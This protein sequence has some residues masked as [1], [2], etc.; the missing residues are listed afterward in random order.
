MAPK[1]GAFFLF[2]KLLIHTFIIT[3]FFTLLIGCASVATYEDDQ[4][5][6]DM[7]LN[8]PKSWEGSRQIPGIGG[9][10]GRGM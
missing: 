5:F 6:S 7:P 3:V 1:D 4:E 10:P 2:M 8:T 9:L